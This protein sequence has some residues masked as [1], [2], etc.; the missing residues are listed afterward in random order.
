MSKEKQIEEMVNDL[1]ECHTEVYLEEHDCWS[2]DFGKMAEAL[3]KRGYRK[4]SDI[5]GKLKT[6]DSFMDALM[7]RFLLLCNYNDY[8]KLNLLKIDDV[9]NGVYEEQ[10]ERVL[11]GG[12]QNGR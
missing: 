8:N 12:E 2:V 4:Q 3:V 1:R 5:D 6:I 11:K 9:V 10:I 7:D